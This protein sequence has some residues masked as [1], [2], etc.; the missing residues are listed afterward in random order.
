[1]EDNK[2]TE[3]EKK[4]YAI[5]HRT[6]LIGS[7]D[8]FIADLRQIMPPTCTPNERKFLDRV[9]EIGELVDY[10]DENLTDVIIFPTG[11]LDCIDFPGVNLKELVE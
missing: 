9:R 1:M 10:G 11:K 8:D 7:K 6:I 4:L 5:A 2:L 3:F